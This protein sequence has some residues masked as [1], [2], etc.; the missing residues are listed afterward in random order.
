MKLYITGLTVAFSDTPTE[1]L[2]FEDVATFWRL[3]RALESSKGHGGQ[4]VK[5]FIPTQK[6]YCGRL[7]SLF[8][9]YGKKYFLW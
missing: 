6:G 2:S 7:F 8:H 4:L 1:F 5:E 9:M 3:C